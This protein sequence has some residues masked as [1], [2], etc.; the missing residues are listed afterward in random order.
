M[1]QNSRN[2]P[3]FP[4]STQKTEQPCPGTSSACTGWPTAPDGSLL[5]TP[6]SCSCGPPFMPLCVSS[7]PVAHFCVCVCAWKSGSPPGG[8]GCGWEGCSAVACPAS[9]AASVPGRSP[10]QALPGRPCAVP[11]LWQG[12]GCLISWSVRMSLP[13]AEGRPGLPEGA[14][15]KSRPGSQGPLCP[16]GLPLWIRSGMPVRRQRRCAQS[17]DPAR[18]RGHF[19]CFCPEAW[20]PLSNGVQLQPGPCGGRAGDCARAGGNPKCPR[21]SRR[22]WRDASGWAS[23]TPGLVSRGHLREHEWSPTSVPPGHSRPSHA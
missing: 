7:K 6:T 18:S 11:E 21:V 8:L 17:G 9:M 20:L 10:T 16:G 13:C 12:Q 1:G 14:G 23:S 4:P 5:A 2:P 19:W 22:V 15:R 3:L